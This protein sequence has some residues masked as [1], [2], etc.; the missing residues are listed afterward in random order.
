MATTAVVVV[1]LG[2]LLECCTHEA[3]VNRGHEANRVHVVR[4]ALWY[5]LGEFWLVYQSFRGNNVLGAVLF[6]L[7]T[8]T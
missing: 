6:R 7:L 3:R 8:D 1:L 5:D 4:G 2:L